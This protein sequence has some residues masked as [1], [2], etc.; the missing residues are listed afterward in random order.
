VLS[1]VCKLSLS[2]IEK[3]CARPG[4]LQSHFTLGALG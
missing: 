3:R 2:L 4:E 1:K